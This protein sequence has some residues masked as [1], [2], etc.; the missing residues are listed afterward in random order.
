[1]NLKIV[2]P[3]IYNTSTSTNPEFKVSNKP[4]IERDIAVDVNVTEWTWSVSVSDRERNIDKR[5]VT[6]G[7]VEV[8]DSG[9]GYELGIVKEVGLGIVQ[10][11]GLND[12]V[13][14]GILFVGVVDGEPGVPFSGGGG[15]GVRVR[16]VGDG[17][18][19]NSEL[20]DLRASDYQDEVPEKEADYDHDD[21][22]AEAVK[23]TGWHCL[24]FDYVGIQ[25]EY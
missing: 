1:M 8:R 21:E 13:G 15:A 16:E 7:L 19:V 25:A 10:E 17:E 18:W 23:A 6:R 9:H 11:R 12:V 20:G 3:P 22:Y 4:H 14:D 24:E 5:F 2:T